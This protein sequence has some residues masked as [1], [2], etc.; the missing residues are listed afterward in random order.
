MFSLSSLALPNPWVILAVVVL[1]AGAGSGGIAFGVKYERGQE[2]RQEVLV[3]KVADAAQTA[4]A[5]AIAKIQP[6]YVTIQ[7]KTQ[8]TIREVPVYRDCHN[9]PDEYRLLNDA[10]TNGES[11][12]ADGSQLPKADAAH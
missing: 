6:K 7:Q 9:T 3:Q 2:A 12:P 4:A 11:E 8:E 10:L 1:L 5:Q